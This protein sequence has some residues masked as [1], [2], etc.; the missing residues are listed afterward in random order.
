M[1]VVRLSLCTMMLKIVPMIAAEAS[2]RSCMIEA[3]YSY[4]CT[5]AFQTAWPKEN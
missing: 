2:A 3:H 1:P 5:T 4:I